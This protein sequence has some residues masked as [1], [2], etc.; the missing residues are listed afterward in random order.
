MLLFTQ[1]LQTLFLS[2]TSKYSIT[3][4]NTGSTSYLEFK[5]GAAEVGP[6]LLPE[7]VR[8]DDERDVDAGRE[9]LLQDLQ[10]RLDAV[11]L[12]ATHVNNDREAMFTH[13]LAG[14]DRGWR[15]AGV[16]GIKEKRWRVGMGWVGG[17]GPREIGES[18][19][20]REREMT[21]VGKD[22][23]GMMERK[24]Q[25]EEGRIEKKRKENQNKQ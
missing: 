6:L 13:L 15:S 23:R 4:S 11:P 1:Q 16:G 9:R 22:E 8:F 18:L 3:A 12:G 19:I 24:G 25:M 5:L 10:Q 20:R 17:R 14:M 7:V 2:K 21:V